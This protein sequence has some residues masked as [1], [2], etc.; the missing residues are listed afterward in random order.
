MAAALEAGEPVELAAWELPPDLP[1]TF[2]P[3]DRVT[4]EP[5]GVL[6]LALPRGRLGER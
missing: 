2:A 3:S 1:H 4:V 5:D 6:S